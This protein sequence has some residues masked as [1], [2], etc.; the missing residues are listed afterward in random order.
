MRK[1]ICLFAV[2]SV[3]LHH[4]NLISTCPVR[5]TERNYNSHLR[6]QHFVEAVDRLW[7]AKF[8][9]R[10]RLSYLCRT[11]AE[12]PAPQFYITPKQ[13]L[14]QYNRWEQTGEIRCEGEQT[15]RMYLDIFT[16]FRARYAESGGIDFKYV[17]MQEVLEQP[18]PSFYINP[19]A[20]LTFYYR[21]MAHRR[22]RH[23][24]RL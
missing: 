16:R 20:A 6:Q 13:A 18:A 22:S 1:A 15:R 9:S 19:S 17:V 24:K 14:E 21:A 5:L 2:L 7:K 10:P 8:I 12:S 3:P 11:V 23:S 4:T